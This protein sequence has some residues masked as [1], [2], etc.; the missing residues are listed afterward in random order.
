MRE[1]GEIQ[2]NKA[3]TSTSKSPKRSTTISM[4]NG[5]KFSLS[6]P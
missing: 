5:N 3:V 2:I 1:S 6:V 4:V